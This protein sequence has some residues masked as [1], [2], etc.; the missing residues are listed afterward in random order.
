MAE[1]RILVTGAS[2][3]VG[4]D[5]MQHYAEQ[6]YKVT[7]VSRK[8][9]L[10]TYGAEFL[11]VD[12]SDPESCKRALSPLTDIVQIVFAALHEEADLVSGWQA[13]SHIDRNALMLRNTVEA[14]TPHAKGLKNITILQGP[15]G[16]EHS[17]ILIFLVCA[18]SK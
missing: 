3:L 11:S 1:G 10:N 14:V 15:K 4:R 5:C 9:P 12:L 16:I 6:G 18:E 2:G 8:K 7:A 17:Y 13:Q